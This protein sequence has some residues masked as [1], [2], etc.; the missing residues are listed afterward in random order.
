MNEYIKKSLELD[1]ETGSIIW[2]KPFFK[3]MVG[4]DATVY[5]GSGYRFISIKKK[6][7]AA[8]RIAWFLF[9]GKW[10]SGQID[11]INGIRNDN[12]ISNLRDVS[13]RDNSCNTIVH[14]SG[15]LPGTLFVKR[16]LKKPWLSRIQ[17]N[18]KHIYLGYFET[19]ALAN[20]AYLK[21]RN[22]LGL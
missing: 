21:K 20:K 3:R 7:M 19:E 22:E 11:H 15:R 9:Y 17:V 8:H 2:S 5:H 14:R 1:P 4:K 10:P 6:Y 18:K 12:R 13:G 16:G